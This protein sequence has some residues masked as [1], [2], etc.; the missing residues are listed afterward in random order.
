MHTMI[1]EIFDRGYQA[2]RADFHAGIDRGLARLG[3]LPREIARGL[4][5]LNRLQWSAPWAAKPAD[6]RPPNRRGSGLA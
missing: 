4:K 2:G 5:L 1:D 3:R 6:G